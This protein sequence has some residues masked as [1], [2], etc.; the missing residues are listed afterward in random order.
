MFLLEPCSSTTT[1]IVLSLCGLAAV[2][3][4]SHCFFIR[5]FAAP[6]PP[7]LD[8]IETPSGGTAS[9]SGAAASPSST[10][11]ASTT[12]TSA[13]TAADNGSA[14]TM[15]VTSGQQQLHAVVHF[16][17][18]AHLIRLGDQLDLFVTLSTLSQRGLVFVPLSVIVQR[19]DVDAALL[20]RWLRCL[21]Q[22]DI[23]DASAAMD[24]FKS[25]STSNLLAEDECVTGMFS[26]ASNLTGR[27]RVGELV[28]LF[29]RVPRPLLQDEEEDFDAEDLRKAQE[30]M[31]SMFFRAQLL[32]QLAQLVPELQASLEVGVDVADLGCHNGSPILPLEPRQ[33][34]HLLPRGPCWEV[35]PRAPRQRLF[36]RRAPMV[37]G[38]ASRAAPQSRLVC[39]H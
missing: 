9:G 29:Q 39:V 4:L 5:A 17:C 37:R 26:M 15:G 34:R 31:Y 30:R 24:C 7:P 18:V 1:S 36:A 32:E 8:K 33:Q 19:A 6:R 11:S 12:A 3:K 27:H 21:A 20:E 13:T 22:V 2:L 25:N 28:D 38:S 35:P 16:A 10:N 23:I 14:L